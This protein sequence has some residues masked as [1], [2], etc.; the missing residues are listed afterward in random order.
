[1]IPRTKMFESKNPLLLMSFT[2]SSLN[3]MNCSNIIYELYENKMYS[4][5][6]FLEITTI[7]EILEKKSE[8][9]VHTGRIY[10]ERLSK[11]NH[12]QARCV[13]SIDTFG[14]YFKRTIWCSPKV[15]VARSSYVDIRPPCVSLWE[16]FSCF[17][18]DFRALAF[19]IATLNFKATS[20]FLK[21]WNSIWFDYLFPFF[22]VCVCNYLL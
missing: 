22:C 15:R 17:G 4:Y 9:L 10:M 18:N 20:Q 19:F 5:F 3:S 14:R 7:L 2:I 12:S 8:N 21:L 6:F 1:M 11:W 16:W 13:R